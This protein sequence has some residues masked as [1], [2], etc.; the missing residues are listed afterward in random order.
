MDNRA[1]EF[2]VSTDYS[3]GNHPCRWQYL[4]ICYGDL[5][6]N[7]TCIRVDYYRN[8]E[9]TSTPL[10][11]EYILQT[12]SL[13]AQYTLPIMSSLIGNAPVSSSVSV[14]NDNNRPYE[15]KIYESAR[16]NGQVTNPLF[17]LS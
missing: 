2:R 15:L 9:Y 8:I 16:R 4:F 12:R 13:P 3:D 11:K 7:T 14:V 1:I 5:F 6:P 10:Y 17:M